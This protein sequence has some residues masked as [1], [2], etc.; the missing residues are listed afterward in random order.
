MT[1][2]QQNEIHVKGGGKLR[3]KVRNASKIW[4]DTFERANVKK[5]LVLKGK[6]GGREF[7]LRGLKKERC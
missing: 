1:H 4:K 2:R 6:R 5:A 3:G 7:W